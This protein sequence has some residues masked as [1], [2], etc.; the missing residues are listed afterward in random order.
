MLSSTRKERNRDNLGTQLKD[1][2]QKEG[3]TQKALAEALGVEYYTMVSQMELG[4]ISIPPALWVPIAQT[5]KMDVSTWVLTCLQE[6]QPELFQALFMNR[7]MCDAVHLLNMFHRGQLDHLLK[8]TKNNA[9]P[10]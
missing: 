6:Y 9:N 7:S 1:A 5:L 10:S 4:Y 3:Y 2:R 8:E